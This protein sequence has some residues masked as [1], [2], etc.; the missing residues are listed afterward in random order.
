MAGLQLTDIKSKGIVDG[1]LNSNIFYT[2]SEKLLLGVEINWESRTC[3]ANMVL[4]MPQ[5]HVQLA[6]HTKIQLG[7]GVEITIVTTPRMLQHASFLDSKFA[8]HRSTT[9]RFKS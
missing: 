3:L 7:I 1:L 5:I 8:A 9:N 6:K 2:L 4:M